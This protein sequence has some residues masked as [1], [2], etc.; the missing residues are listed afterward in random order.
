MRIFLAGAAGAIGR[1]LVPLLVA[2]G[3]E[4]TGTTR[5]QEKAAALKTQGATPAIVDV[6]D[7]SALQQAVADAHP[8]IVIHQ[9][10][11]LSAKNMDEARERNAR[12]RIEATP[13]LMQAAKAAGAR[14][15]VAQSIAFAYAPGPEPLDET[16]PLGL[17]GEGAAKRSA[18]GVAALE[19]A[20]LQTA[21]LEGVAMRITSR[22]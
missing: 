7:A 8:E 14:R 6:F 11:D 20:V 19:R 21:G 13:N 4:V 17:Q 2:T 15:V 22:S 12:I 3:H 1:R 9:L 10:T 16:A 5:S 18:E